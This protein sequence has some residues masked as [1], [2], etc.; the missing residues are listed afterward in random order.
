MRWRVSGPVWGRAWLDDSFDRRTCFLREGGPFALVAQIK[1]K[2][3][4][5]DAIGTDLG[6]VDGEDATQ[7]TR[8]ACGGRD[9]PWTA[10]RFAPLNSGHE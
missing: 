2:P 7:K 4:Y 1:L 9:F 5:T 6:I 3:G 10:P 8:R